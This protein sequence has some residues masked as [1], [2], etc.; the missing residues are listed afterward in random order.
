MSR[1][2]AGTETTSKKLGT[3]LDGQIISEVLC[4]N[5]RCLKCATMT[6][7]K[8]YLVK[9]CGRE[10]QMQHWTSHKKDCKHV[11][12]SPSWQPAWITEKRPPAFL[13]NDN[14]PNHT[15]FG[16]L[17]HYLW[18]NVPAINCLQVS[19][20][21][22]QRAASMDLNLCFAGKN[23]ILT[24]NDLPDNYKGKCTILC[25]DI[26]GVVVNRNL[27]ILYA[28]LTPGADVADAAELAVHL[29]YSAGLTTQMADYLRNCTEA[30]YG[31]DGAHSGVWG[32]RG[33]GKIRTLQYVSSLQYALRMFHSEYTLS[34][35]LASMRSVMWGPTRTDYRDRYIFSLEP[36]HRVSF[37]RFRTTGVLAPFAADVENFTEPNR[38][39]FSAEGKW[40]TMD[41]ANPLFGW[42][43]GPVF[44]C[45][46]RY[47]ATRADS[48]GCL[49]FYLKEQFAKFARR[50][51]DFELDITLSQTEAHALSR[52]IAADSVPNFS[53][54]RFDR[55]ETSNMADSFGARQIISDWAPLLNRENP[56]AVLL[57]NFMNWIL[58]QPNSRARDDLRLLWCV[59]RVVQHMPAPDQRGQGVDGAR[60][61]IG[62]TSSPHFFYLINCAEAFFDNEKP[63]AEFLAKSGAAQAAAAAGAQL[64]KVHRIHPKRSGLSLDDPAQRVPQLTKTGF[65]NLYLL[66]GANYSDRFVEVEIKQKSK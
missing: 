47:G 29:M 38:L 41:D 62:G 59:T 13:T 44:E 17:G 58:K 35:A 40:L 50:V 37:S 49:F 10:C 30:I 57:V 45:G 16:T 43:L 60:A 32:T 21:E 39:I 33:T 12:I 15:A 51:K 14:G 28:L 61:V 11:Y 65:N 24:V 52:A 9:Y 36:S 54:V 64:R 7:G 27:V 53:N 3:A 34:D 18:G 46:A 22:G 25:N 1:N 56:H 8:C 42:D 20:N 31:T 6:C 23:L 2:Y 63:F 26:N 48:Y 55:I 66:G 19:R 5:G 4:A